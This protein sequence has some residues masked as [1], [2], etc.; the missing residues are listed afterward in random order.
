ETRI[1][2]M[3]YVGQGHEIPVLLPT[4]P[5]SA[6]DVS[7]IHAAY[8]QEYMK[9][10]DRP[11]PGSDV[12]VMSFAVVLTTPTPRIA[13]TSPIRDFTDAQSIR[14]Q[15][16]RD[17]STGEVAPWAVYDRALMTTG[18]RVSGPAILCEDET[19]TLVGPGWRASVNN[20]GYLEIVRETA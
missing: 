12:E 5:L 7:K 1:A 10:F 15:L 2:F 17:T 16:V 14:S 19:S 11:V 4:R 3:R 18:T 20:L 13:T 8:E 6:A 9:Y